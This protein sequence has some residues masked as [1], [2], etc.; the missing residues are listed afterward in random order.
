[1]R[2]FRITAGA[3]TLLALVACGGGEQAQ[4]DAAAEMSAAAATPSCYLTASMEDAQARPSPL[5]T[6]SFTVGGHEGLLCYGAPSANGRVVMG[7]LVPLG[8]AWRLGANEATAIHLTGP[9]MVG[10][11]GLDAGSYSLY[12]VPGEA[13]WTFHVNGTVERWGIPI[14]DDVTAA[15]VATFTAPVEATDAPVETLTFGFSPSGNGGDLVLEWEN[16]RVRIS[17]SPGGA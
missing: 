3:L 2:S 7:E 13:E 15:D 10:G 5:R 9:A 1:M 11:V 17:L 12:A 8:A 4:P 14:G 16:T 6:T